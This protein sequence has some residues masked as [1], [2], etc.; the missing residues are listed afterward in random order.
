MQLI[1]QIAGVNPAKQPIEAKSGTPASLD[2]A[3][4]SAL[5]S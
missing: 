1:S 4:N 5:K 3:Q 2:V